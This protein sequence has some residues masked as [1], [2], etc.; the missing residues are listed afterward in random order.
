MG[1]QAIKARLKHVA[2]A[3]A[4][5]AIATHVLFLAANVVERAVGIVGFPAAQTSVISPVLDAISNPIYARIDVQGVHVAV[6][7]GVE[8]RSR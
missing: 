5:S 7:G 2:I 8:R 1:R 3:I 6:V 4:Q